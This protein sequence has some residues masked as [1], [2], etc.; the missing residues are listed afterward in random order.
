M[1]NKK[2]GLHIARFTRSVK[3]SYAG[4]FSSFMISV[5]YI[6]FPAHIKETNKRL[7]L[8]IFYATSK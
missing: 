7:A 6:K 8:K 1:R 5:E 2:T 4:V 3:N